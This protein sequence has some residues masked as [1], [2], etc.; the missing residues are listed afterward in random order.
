MKRVAL[1]RGVP[2]SAI[3]LD[4]DGLNTRSTA[5]NTA[6]IF[7]A[8]GA[9]RIIAV[10]HFYHL[11]RVKLAYQQ[12]GW[13]VFTVPARSDRT[14]LKLPVFMARETVALFKYYFDP[15]IPFGRV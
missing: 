8:R 3:V 2:E 4:Y 14:L 7:K 6:K 11:P 15:I 12:E 10:S 1:Q 13:D 5:Q 9:R